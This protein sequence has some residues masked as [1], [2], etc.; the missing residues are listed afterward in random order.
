M[1]GKK[2]MV[3]KLIY[4]GLGIL[5]ISFTIY[6]EPNSSTGKAEPATTRPAPEPIV[7]LNQIVAVVNE[8]I[9]TQTDLDQAVIDFKQQLQASHAPIPSDYQ[10]REDA[11]QQLI[12][13]RMQLQM[14][15]RNNIKPTDAE[16]DNALDEI[17]KSHNVNLDQLK[18]Q[19]RRQNTS[20]EEFR[21]KVTEQLIVSKLLQMMIAGKVQVTDQDIQEYKN[22]MPQVKEYQ[23]ADFFLPLPEKPTAQQLK[24]TLAAAQEIQ[25]QIEQGLDIHSI[26][27]E[28]HDLGWRTK[29]DLPQLFVDQLPNLTLQNSSPPIL[30]PNGY[31][32][33]KLLGERD[34]NALTEDQIKNLVFQKKYQAAAKE[35]MDKARKQAYIQI[36]V[37]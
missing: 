5:A 8:E 35:A 34:K 26:S 22:Q 18:E 30:A 21:K 32:V 29:E 10:L 33:L 4:W 27:P 17:A 2:L 25:K 31:H 24:S 14:A 6:A 13:Y 19:L 37:P 9:I 20:Y 3:K 12:N 15:A 16:V 23:L 28:F 36:M 7:P 11:L 1:R